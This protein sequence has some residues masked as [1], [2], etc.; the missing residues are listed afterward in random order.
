MTA[1]EIL[2]QLANDV[3][4]IKMDTALTKQAV[5]GN[6]V[7]GLNERMGDVEKRLDAHPRDCPLGK[8][9]EDTVDNPKERKTN[10]WTVFF[11]IT[12]VAGIAGSLA[13]AI[14]K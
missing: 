12:G 11:G 4:E 5:V 2:Q 1:D 10:G 8:H 14:L 9:V 7:K 6:G 13:V 3:A